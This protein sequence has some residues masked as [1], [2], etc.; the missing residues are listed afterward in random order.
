MNNVA[1]CGS[2][3]KFFSGCRAS[4]ISDWD[5]LTSTTSVPAQDFETDGGPPP[6]CDKPVH[7]LGLASSSQKRYQTETWYPSRRLWKGNANPPVS[8]STMT[9]APNGPGRNK[10]AKWPERVAILLRCCQACRGLQRFARFCALSDCC[11]WQV[12]YCDL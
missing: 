9:H 6:P 2:L 5:G 8:R 11:S 1:L 12:F 10:Q 3:R 7:K 4:Q